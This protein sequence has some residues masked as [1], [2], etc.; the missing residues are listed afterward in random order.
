MK[1]YLKHPEETAQTL[2]QHD[3]GLTW[4]YTGDLGSMDSDGF[5]YFRGRIKR[6]IVSSG[7]TSTPPRS[8]TC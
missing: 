3:D 4:L 6:M 2:R 7:T 8:K 5:I 1:G